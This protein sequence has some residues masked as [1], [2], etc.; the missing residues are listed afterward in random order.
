M[1]RDGGNRGLEKIV[2]DLPKDAPAT[3]ELL[4]AAI[5]GENRFRLE[6]VPIWAYGLAFEDVV[7]GRTDADGRTHYTQVLQ[8]S[9]LLTVRIAGPDAP[10]PFFRRIV[11]KVAEHSVATEHYSST[12]SAF[13]MTRQKF[14]EIA[15]TID[16]A[17]E[18]GLIFVEIANGEDD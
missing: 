16:E 14:D 2:V 1:T 15:T 5:V 17:E 18:T 6:N 12:Y 9:G 10:A 8:R 3:A 7:E 4:W 11:E 13:A